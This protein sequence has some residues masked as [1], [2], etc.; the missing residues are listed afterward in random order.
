LAFVS[1][2]HRL[3]DAAQRE[4]FTPLPVTL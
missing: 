1:L 3:R 4:G 2:D